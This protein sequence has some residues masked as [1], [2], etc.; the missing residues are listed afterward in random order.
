[1]AIC[2]AFYSKLLTFLDAHHKVPAKEQVDALLK[3]LFALSTVTVH[4]FNNR[5]SSHADLKLKVA[6]RPH[7]GS[8]I[9]AIARYAPSPRPVPQFLPARQWKVPPLPQFAPSM[10][11]PQSAGRQ[12]KVAPRIPRRQRPQSPPRPQSPNRS[13]PQSSTHRRL[14]PAAASAPSPTDGIPTDSAPCRLPGSPECDPLSLNPRCLNP[15]RR[16]RSRSSS[17][18][19]TI[20]SPRP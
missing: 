17:R 11:R 1:M 15:D 20:H 3:E 10:P 13:R 19:P 14:L 16:P 4:L 8:A 9:A 18:H 5:P 6:R 2:D 7:F 12:W